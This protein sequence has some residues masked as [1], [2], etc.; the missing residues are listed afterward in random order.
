L[1]PF[2]YSF[3]DSISVDRESGTFEYL[4]VF[5]H[6]NTIGEYVNKLGYDMITD[7]LVVDVHAF[8][9]QDNSG[10]LPSNHSLQFGEGGI[11]DAEDGE[12][13]VHE[14]VHSLSELASPDNTI[15]VKKGKRWKK[16]RAIIFLRLTAGHTM[17]THPIKYFLG[18]AIR[19]GM[20]SLSILSVYILKTFLTR[21]M[22]IEIYGQ[23]H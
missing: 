20:V 3:I 6:I 13:V 5:Y 17:I 8:G 1:I 23:V 21:K 9:G 7:T 16:A 4:N 14:F 2:T 18:M 19:P 11:D 15:G 10:Y 22:E 12:V